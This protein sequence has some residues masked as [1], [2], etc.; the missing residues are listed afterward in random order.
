MKNSERIT[1][2]AA[3][4]SA[5]LSMACCLPFALPVALGV[6][7]LSIVLDTLRPWLI[8]ASLAFLVVGFVQL[9]RKRACERRSKA[10][11]VILGVATLIVLSFAFL[12]QVVATLLAGSR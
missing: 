9:F 10:S 4:V 11:L 12:P 2:V 8:G 7:G 3:V 1:P 5:V 6:A